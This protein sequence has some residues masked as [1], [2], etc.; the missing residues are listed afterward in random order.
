LTRDGEQTDLRLFAVVVLRISN[1]IR[2]DIF[3]HIDRVK[4]AYGL[5]YRLPPVAIGVTTSS[6]EVHSGSSSEVFQL[7]LVAKIRKCLQRL[8]SPTE[9]R[10]GECVLHL[11]SIVDN[12]AEKIVVT[13]LALA[14]R[15]REQERSESDPNTIS[16]CLWRMSKDYEYLPEKASTE[17][18]DTR[19]F[20][21]DPIVAVSWWTRK[22]HRMREAIVHI[23]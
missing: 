22:P 11:A 7:E 17:R 3:I 8:Q 12:I 2:L 10:D 23:F 13:I 9:R 15:S 5:G 20:F 19:D 14:T 1:D 16:I 18:R 6:S 4:F 21:V